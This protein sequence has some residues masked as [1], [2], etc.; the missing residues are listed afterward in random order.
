MQIKAILRLA[1][2]TLTLWGTSALTLAP[3]AWA[4]SPAFE[5]LVTRTATGYKDIPGTNVVFSAAAG[6]KSYLWSRNL[7]IAGDA[8]LG[9]GDNIGSTAA[10]RCRQSN[11]QEVPA[12]TEAGAYWATNQVPPNE[13]S[14]A[15]YLRWVFTA[16][17][18]GTYDCRLSV[19]SY[20]SVIHSGRKVTMTV[21]AGAQLARQPYTTAARWT[22][23]KVG[24]A[25]GTV[26]AQG[27]THTTL[28][29]TYTPGEG[30]DITVVQDAALTTCVANSPICGGEGSSTY[31][32]TQTE[33]WVEAQPQ[34]P[35]GAK[36]GGPIK[37]GIGKWNISDA[38]HHQSA[39]NVLHLTKA[40]LGGCTRIR[41]VLK[42]RHVD[43]NP[44]NL[45]FGWAPGRIAATHGLAF[46][47]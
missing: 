41:T 10:V 32:G 5:Y 37:G 22:L 4:V 38:K 21:P 14:V 18:A 19:T 25:K 3:E 16:P 28:G 36:C 1:V 34:N 8:T 39:T 7:T 23:P 29:Y 11:G 30:D 35:D 44:V 2:A 46:T 12:D 6:E 20:S 13:K 42:I 47:Y 33:S 43:G 31:T 40:Q 26:I 27:S 24:E 17:T 15:P 45:H 9:A